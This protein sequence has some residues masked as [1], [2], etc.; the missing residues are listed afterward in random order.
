[1]LSKGVIQKRF[2]YVL[3]NMYN[4]PLGIF[5]RTTNPYLAFTKGKLLHDSHWDK[6]LENVA[7]KSCLSSYRE[8]FNHFY[9][10]LVQHGLKSGLPKDV[11]SEIAQETMLRVWKQAHTFDVSKGQ[12][13]QWIF[14]I[15]R[16]L[17]FDYLRKLRNDPLKATSS[18]IYPDLEILESHSLE[19]GEAFDLGELKR[20][21][22]LL[23]EEQKFI[24]QKIYFE[25]MSHQ[26]VAASEN[27]PLGT[28]KSRVRLA[29]MSM[30]K[31]MEETSQ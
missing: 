2:F 11:S 3:I 1:M 9:P 10:L 22:E 12:I 26:E 17:K 13:S 29:I 20:N 21:I 8:I 16:N 27:I 4:E 15:A 19:L 18:D 31:L 24:I 23:P 6:L 14:V 28:V 25:G 7:A 30:K 5:F